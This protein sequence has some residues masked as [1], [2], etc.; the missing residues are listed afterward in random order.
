MPRS[1]SRQGPLPGRAA[2][3]LGIRHAAD[4]VPV[5]AGDQQPPPPRHPHTRLPSPSSPDPDT[6]EPPGGPSSAD[7]LPPKRGA[8]LQQSM[9]AQND[10]PAPAHSSVFSPAPPTPSYAQR[11]R[12]LM[13]DL[14]WVVLHY[15]RCFLL[16]PPP[17]PHHSNVGA[18]NPDQP[19]RGSQAAE[20]PP[21]AAPP[22]PALRPPGPAQ[23]RGSQG[24]RQENNKRHGRGG[25]IFSKLNASTFSRKER[26]CKESSPAPLLTLGLQ[27]SQLAGSTGSNRHL[28]LGDWGLP[29][30][31]AAPRLLGPRGCQSPA[32]TTAN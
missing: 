28:V 30:P 27:G 16:L 20:E 4:S 23:S 26:G 11:P 13:L 18:L 22:L 25:V 17:S 6:G 2:G 32:T 15:W 8:G 21:A 9:R 1:G 12:C 31:A 5:E 29:G 3:G 14:G 7:F 24:W 10:R 19:R